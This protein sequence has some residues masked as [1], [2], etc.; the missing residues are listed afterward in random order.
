MHTQGLSHDPP[1]PRPTGKI[2][3]IRLSYLTRYARDPLGFVGRRFARFGDIYLIKTGSDRTYVTK[4]PEHLRIMLRTRAAAFGKPSIGLEKVLGNGLLNANGDIWRK[5]RRL[6]QP[7]FHSKMLRSYADI[8][9]EKTREMA[10]PWRSGTQLDLAAEMMRTTLRIVCA[11][12]FDHNIRGHSDE[13]GASMTVFQE[14]LGA[15]NLVPEW[16]PTRHNRRAKHALTTMDRLVYGLIDKRREELRT[17]P[18]R[19]ESTDLLTQLLQLDDG[20]GGLPRKALRDELLTLFLAGHETTSNALSWAF[21]LLAQHPAIEARLHAEL[22]HVLAGRLPTFDDLE[23]LPY[24]RNIIAEAMRLYP[25]AYVI[26][27]QANEDVDIGDYTIKSG[28]TCT[29]WI[30]MVHHDP[31]LFPEPEV[32]KPERFEADD[33]NLREAYLPFGAGARMCIGATFAK[34]EMALVLATL[35]QRVQFR[36]PPGHRVVP[37]PK[38]TLTPAGGVPVTVLTRTK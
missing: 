18:A 8:M 24:T 27:R 36:L 1:G 5:N 28:S 12:L 16:I 31:K 7:A 17:N 9:V 25:P 20:E 33:P 6:I 21:V 14:T 19:A 29:A 2:S 34:M 4:N 38:I 11:A 3:A 37:R 23:N 35:A 10:A 26:A 15:L 22:Q 32:F 30:Y 13:V